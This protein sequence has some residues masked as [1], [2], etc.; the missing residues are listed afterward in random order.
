VEI[1][2]H[3]AAIQHQGELLATAAAQQDWLTPLPTCPDWQLRDLV[4]HLGGVHRWA[5]RHV[6]ERLTKPIRDYD[7]L[8]GPFPDDADLIDWFRQ[9]HARLVQTLTD[10]APDVECWSFLPAPSPLAFWARRQAHETGIHRAD[11]EAPRGVITPYPPKLASDGIDELLYCFASRPG[12]RLRADPARSM[13]A[14]ATDQPGEW[15]IQI[16]P[17]GVTVNGTHA[18]A[19]CSVSGS[20]SDLYLFL[21]NRG[22]RDSLS[23]DGDAQLLDAWRHDVRVRW[24]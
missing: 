1:A 3:I 24:S 8:A 6:A 12:G 17:D 7:P 21:W 23:I 16:A 15:T 18:D 22:G 11:A 19:D 2:E 9:G 10:A 4:R 13:H 5:T 14:H 20:A